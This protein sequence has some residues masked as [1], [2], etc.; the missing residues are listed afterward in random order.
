MHQ[1]KCRR[2]AMLILVMACIIVLFV[3]ALFCVDV[4]Y[5]QML[6]SEHQVAVDAAAKAGAEALSREQSSEAAY[7]A[8]IRFAAKNRIGGQPTIISRNDIELGRAEQQQDGSWLFV[9][10]NKSP[11]AVR[12]NSQQSNLNLFFGKIFGT[13][14]FSPRQVATAAHLD[15]EIV[16]AI[17]RSHSMCF[18]LSGVDWSYPPGI[19]TLP[20][21]VVYPPHP[22]L[23]RWSSLNASVKLFL[24][25]VQQVSLVPRVGLVTWGS[26]I[27]L[28][29]YEGQLTNRTFPAVTV[30]VPLGTDFAAIESKINYRSNDTMLGGTNMSSGMQAAIDMLTAPDALPLANKTIILMTDGKWN[31]GANP[32]ELAQTAK[33]QD[34]V[35]HTITFLPRADQKDMKFV[36]KVTGGTHYHA[37]SEAELQDAFRELARILPVVLT[38]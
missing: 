21:P 22:T 11:T 23:S 36:A 1:R 24:A 2:G 34:I 20:D 29:T 13:G 6:Q 10:D 25:E 9:A 28:D 12:V 30:D 33:K 7:E 17:D 37:T 27:G 26:D 15:Q 8:A 18:D 3:A 16:L 14:Y 32:K 31:E 4:A 19:P 5:M 35:I 38:D